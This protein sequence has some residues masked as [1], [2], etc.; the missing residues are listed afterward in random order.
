MLAASA[1]DGL[2]R[3]CEPMKQGLQF[4]FTGLLSFYPTAHPSHYSGY[5]RLGSYL[6]A[7]IVQRRR[8]ETLF[9]PR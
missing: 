4:L 1:D 9:D 6:C 7:A 5:A 3:F 8:Q 2:I